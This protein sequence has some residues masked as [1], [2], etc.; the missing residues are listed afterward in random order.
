VQ[1]QT[2]TFE[3]TR[4]C[5]AFA[6]E[7]APERRTHAGVRLNAQPAFERTPDLAAR[8][9]LSINRTLPYFVYFTFGGALG[10]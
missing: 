6:V 1:T 8:F 2:P 5:D 9:S 10:G 4:R 3:H 7:R